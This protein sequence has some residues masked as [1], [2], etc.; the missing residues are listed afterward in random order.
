MCRV[1]TKN[2]INLLSLDLVDAG[3]SPT[4]FQYDT[5]PEEY[6]Y[7]ISVIFD[8]VDTRLCRPDPEAHL[9]LPDGRT[10]T[11][12]DEVVTF[13]TR[14][15]EEQRGFSTFMHAV[16][17]LQRQ[18]PNLHAVIV[19]GQ[20]NPYGDRANAGTEFKDRLIE[21]V[22]VDT[23]RTHFLG[24]VP[25]SRLQTVFR[26]S[27]VHIYLTVPF[28]L[29]WSLMEAM[30]SA[31]AVVASDTAPVREVVEDG[32]NGRLADFHTP[33]AFVA[34]CNELLDDPDGAADLRRRAR[35]TVLANYDLQ[36]CLKR[37]VALIERLVAGE[38]PVPPRPV[39]RPGAPAFMPPDERSGSER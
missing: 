35:A 13:C 10:L 17:A 24:N 26:V 5:Y 39:H 21:E 36:L 38:R 23:A 11:T 30:A 32:V 31:C 37:Q 9:E 7:K 27:S 25:W 16:A 6:R 12:A 28:V 1:R 14:A 8:G 22:G 3:V 15:Y 4:F 19:G 2:V 34:R 29:S 20:G 18:R 33:A